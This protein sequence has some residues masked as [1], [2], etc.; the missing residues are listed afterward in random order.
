MTPLPS[1]TLIATGGTI[2]G[3]AASDT[4]TTTY[5]A[6]ALPVAT[7]LEA[8]PQLASI[9]TLQVEQP[10]SIDSKDADERCWLTLRRRAA[11]A[12]ARQETDGLVILH[13]TDT[14]E[15]TAYFLARTLDP[16]GKAVV[17]TGAMRPATAL[18]ADGPMNLLDAVSVAADPGACG[19][20]VLV[21]FDRKLYDARSLR[22]RHTS[23]LDAFDGGECGPCGHLAPLRFERCSEPARPLAAVPDDASGLPRVEVLYVA[24][25]SRPD[26]LTCAIQAGA[27]GLVL[28]L[29]GN[30]SLPDVWHPAVRAATASGVPVVRASRCASGRVSPH[31]VD[32][33]TGTRPC[34]ACSPAAARIELMLELLAASGPSASGQTP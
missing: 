10:F 16:C 1:V 23:A 30:G 2:A 3:A 6:G 11:E 20:G 13:G 8:V 4:D 28:A 18:S 25:G 9:A 27:R 34:G 19:K 26:L 15:E 29:P 22:K 7:L 14:L 33:R 17:L 5:T 31:P 24:A 21:C 12:L 32:A